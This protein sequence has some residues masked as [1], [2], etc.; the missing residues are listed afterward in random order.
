VAIGELDDDALARK[1]DGGHRD[2]Q[3]AGEACAAF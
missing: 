1:G 2:E 3:R